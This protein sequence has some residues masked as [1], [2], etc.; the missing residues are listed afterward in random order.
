MINDTEQL[1]DDVRHVGDFKGVTFSKYKKT[2]VK[3]ELLKSM[4][5]GKIEPACNWSAEFICSAHFIELWDAVILFYCKHIHLG[6]PNLAVYLEKRIE[7]F[8]E[9]MRSGYVGNELALRNNPK[10]RRLVAEIMCVCCDTDKKHSIDEVKV[11]DKYFDIT[12]LTDKLKAPHIS[13]ASS[14][15][16]EDDPKELFIATNELAYHL[17][18]ESKNT[19]MACF[20][21]EWIMEFSRLRRMKKEPCVCERRTIAKVDD[22]YHHDVIWLIWDILITQ[23]EKADKRIHKCV[24]SLVSLY[25]LK[26]TTSI[27]KKRRFVVYCAVS[28]ITEH[29]VFPATIVGESTKKKIARVTSQI[30]NVYRAIKVNEEPSGAGRGFSDSKRHNLEKS[31]AKMDVLND[32][33]AK[34]TPRS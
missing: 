28:L 1:I 13:Y 31:I 26:Y 18:S 14:I 5:D 21:I 29:V 30:D 9:L 4:Y 27:Y 23:A 20:W 17:S 33:G 25:S 32:F 7:N 2:D 11:D 16:K 22:K 12:N 6:N 15:M 34:F 19:L 3:K 24:T 10:M 8:K